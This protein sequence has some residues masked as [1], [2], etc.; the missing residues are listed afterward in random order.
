MS[1]QTE[2]APLEARLSALAERFCERAYAE[3]DPRRV[4]ADPLRAFLLDEAASLSEFAHQVREEYVR[5]EADGERPKN[6]QGLALARF[7]RPAFR[8]RTVGAHVCR[9]GAGLPAGYLYVQ[10]S[11]GYEGG[12]APDGSVS[13]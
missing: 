3:V 6:A 5:L 7:L 9:G 1:N 13:T 8:D 11:D 4:H 12:I 2:R 10:L